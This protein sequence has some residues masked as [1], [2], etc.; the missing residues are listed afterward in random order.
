LT[1]DGEF[2]ALAEMI[3]KKDANLPLAVRILRKLKSDKVY[4][5]LI[6]KGKV[7]DAI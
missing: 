7:K 6:R 1:K 2:E 5:I 4:N 3:I